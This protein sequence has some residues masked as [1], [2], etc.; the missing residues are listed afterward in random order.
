MNQTF[1]TCFVSEG[2]HSGH[3]ILP[4]FTPAAGACSRVQQLLCRGI[5]ALGEEIFDRRYPGF[6]LGREHKCCIKRLGAWVPTIPLLQLGNTYR[7]TQVNYGLW[8][9]MDVYGCLWMFMHVYECLWM[10][11]VDTSILNGIINQLIIWTPLPKQ[12]GS[13]W[14]QPM[15]RIYGRNYCGW[16]KSCTTL[17]G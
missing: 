13:R 12:N 16:K 1:P 15:Y 4:C 5:Q 6:V 17:D 9:F 14:D 10:F 7:Y 2:G 11:M 8:M 3:L